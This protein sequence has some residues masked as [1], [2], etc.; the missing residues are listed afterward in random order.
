M[1]M[2]KVMTVAEAKLMSNV[3]IRSYGEFLSG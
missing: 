2:Q 3:K 1:S